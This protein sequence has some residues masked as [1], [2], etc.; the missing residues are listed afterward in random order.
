MKGAGVPQ[1]LKRWKATPSSAM[2]QKFFSTGYAMKLELGQAADGTIPGKIF[3]ALPDPEQSVVAGIFKVAPASTEPAAQPV[4][5][6][7]PAAAAPSG[8]NRAAFDK[9]YGIQKR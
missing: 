1:I 8:G 5:D 9:R 4:A 7:Q 6:Q 2:Q 3:L